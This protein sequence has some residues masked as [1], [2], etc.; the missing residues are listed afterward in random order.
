MAIVALAVML[1]GLV[2]V[3]AASSKSDPG[4]KGLSS[5]ELLSHNKNDGKDACPND[6]NAGK[7]NDNKGP[8]GGCRQHPPTGNY[9]NVN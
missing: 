6:G 9:G 2:A 1:L 5:V 3:Y 4:A 7:G 8:N